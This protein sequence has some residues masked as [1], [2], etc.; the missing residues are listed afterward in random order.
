ME[1]THANLLNLIDWH[2][3]AFGVTPA[4]RAGQV[5]GLGFDAA[6][7]EIWPTLAAG[8]TL[9]I[10][11]ELTRRSP[12]ALRDWLV[13]EKIT[14]SFVPTVLAEQLLHA[15]WPAGTALRT[16]LTG[17]DTLHRRPAADLPFVLVN[18]Y[19]PTECTVVS[20]S[21]IVMPGNATTASA[22]DGPP[23]IGRP[24]TNTTALILDPD[25]RPVPPGEPGELCLGGAL[26]G[27]GYR[28]D[29]QLTASRFVTYSPPSGPAMR[30]YRTGDRARLLPS[31]EIAF[32]GRLD[33]QIKIRG[34][35]VEPGEI[36][37]CLD[38]YPTIQASAVVVRNGPPGQATEEP[39]LVAYVV[40]EGM[41]RPAA[42]DLREYL[43]AR[44]PDYMIPAKYVALASLPTTANGKLDKSALPAPTAENLLR[45]AHVAKATAPANSA[46]KGSADSAVE[47]RLTAIIASLLGQPTVAR[48]QNFF[49]IGGHSMLGVQLVAR[50]RDTFGVKLALRQLFS[51][52][53]AAA[54]SAEVKRL[55]QSAGK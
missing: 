41:A 51:A 3:A 26:V 19:G 23:S 40:V 2:V 5:A 22:Q 24:I 1:I 39:A 10:A 29:P 53:T 48:D 31:G 14:I 7:W 46:E 30:V 12:Q 43:A 36:V 32:M 18:N 4:D 47:S 50:I 20:T 27:R 21:G 55:L 54:L 37:G 11:D 34:Y 13:A 6:A 15:D 25:L 33:D 45:D 52:P 8:A 35:R 28:N 42:S 38:R 16:M 9:H 44:L 17:A 49:L